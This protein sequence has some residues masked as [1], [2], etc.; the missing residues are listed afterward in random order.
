MVRPVGRSVGRFD[1]APGWFR[2]SRATNGRERRPLAVRAA[3]GL[4]C[5]PSLSVKR[6]KR[7]NGRSTRLGS[8]LPQNLKFSVV[9]SHFFESGSSVGRIPLM[10]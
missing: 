10:W 3:V 6:L 2:P 8:F 5:G 9:I 7:L 1:L 4:P